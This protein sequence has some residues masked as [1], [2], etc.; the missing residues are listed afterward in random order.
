M[1]VRMFVA[2]VVAMLLAPIADAKDDVEFMSVAEMEQLLA[3]GP[4]N[5]TFKTVPEGSKLVKYKIQLKEFISLGHIRIVVFTS[6]HFVAAGMSGSPVMVKGL[7]GR[8]KLFGALSYSMDQFTVGHQWGGVTP[9]EYMHAEAQ[10]GLEAATVA[11]MPTSFTYQGVSFTP[12]DTTVRPGTI[13]GARDRSWPLVAGMPITADILEWTGSDGVSTT[14]G[15]TGTITYVSPAGEI[16]AFGH[17]MLGARNVRYNFRTCRILGT[18]Y[19]HMSSHKISGEESPVLGTIEYDGAYGIYGRVGGASER[20]VTEFT[21]AFSRA[22]KPTGSFQVKMATSPLTTR[23]MG[24]AFKL[25]G[26]VAKVP[27][28]AQ[29]STVAFS[30]TMKLEGHAPVE[31]SQVF[32]SSQF[33]FGPNT[34]RNSSYENATEAFLEGVYTPI[35]THRMGFKIMGT[36][37]S[38]DFSDGIAPS[39]KV[40][41]VKFPTTI[42]YGENPVMELLLV[43]EDNA[44]TLSKRTTVPLD[45]STIEQPTY[46]ADTK[47]TDKQSEKVV[48]GSLAVYSVHYLGSFLGENERE[49]EAPLYFLD[50]KDYLANFRKNLGRSNRMLYA[51]V[52]VRKRSGLDEAATT[53]PTATLVAEETVDWIKSS[54]GLTERKVTTHKETSVH[55]SANPPPVPAGYMVAPIT[56]MVQFEVVQ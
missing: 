43:S 16:Y 24:F 17:P 9:I 29:P 18:V 35:S 26:E 22:G 8:T 10:G 55:F 51:R 36:H 6:K 20:P 31:Y 45:W 50:A 49:V 28:D 7:D 33:Q 47:D 40:A 44:V 30:S 3:K 48:R 37:L 54:Q 5:A 32:T 42:K 34:V 46:T 14:T 13:T 19:S 2:V 56:K 11:S 23:I 1:R 21:A 41:S 53:L 15:S 52:M 25:I 39:L 12:I 27:F 4:V 38:F